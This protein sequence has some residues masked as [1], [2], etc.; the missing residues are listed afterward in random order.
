[1]LPEFG[2]EN[3][4][5]RKLWIESVL[6]KIPNGLR[7]LDA[8]AGECAN[9]KY[10]EHLRYVSQDFAQYDGRGNQKGIQIENWIY[11]KIDI[12][13]DIASIPEPN[14]SFDAILCTEVLEHLPEPIAALKEFYRLLKSNGVLVLTAPFC[15]MTHMAPYHYY[16]GFNRYFYEKHLK[17][18][19]YS[20]ILIQTSGNYFQYLAQEI[21]RSIHIIEQYDASKFTFIE[22]WARK[23]ML[24]ALQRISKNAKDS[25]DLLTYGYFVI[26]RK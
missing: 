26:A 1:M 19:G 6:K 5:N 21:Y 22:L 12:I 14:E 20:K 13:C 4:Y 11:P 24:K 3:D 9:K 23:I 7:I 2:K 15:S 16:S 10:C 25:S 8:G 17:E 18:I